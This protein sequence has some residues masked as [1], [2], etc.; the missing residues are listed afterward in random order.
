MKGRYVTRDGLVMRVGSTEWRWS[1][2]NSLSLRGKQP[3]PT[4]HA[5]RDLIV[6]AAMRLVGIREVPTRSNWGPGVRAIQSATGAYRA[7]WCVSTVQSIWKRVLGSTWAQDTANAYF[8]ADY[9]RQHGATILHPIPG[10]AVVYHLGD[11]HAGT[12]VSVLRDGR[13]WAV[14]GNWGDAVVHILRDPRSIPCTFILRP[15]L[16]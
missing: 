12:V 1:I 2:R 9:A 16:R 6:A 7:P 4:G 8:L 10:C 3:K 14:E 5:K 13:F 15:E 11:G